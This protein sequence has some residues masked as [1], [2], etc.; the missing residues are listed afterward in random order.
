MGWAKQ[1]AFA[2]AFSH[3]VEKSFSILRIGTALLA[4]T[5]CWLGRGAGEGLE[6][7]A[8]GLLKRW[9]APCYD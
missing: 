7:V 5:G 3:L 6:Q 4:H 9:T 2:A 8:T 1:E